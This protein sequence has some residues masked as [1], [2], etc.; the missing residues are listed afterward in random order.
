[1]SETK[2][3][4]NINWLWLRSLIRIVEDSDNLK[5]LI[6][7]VTGSLKN[8][9]GFEECE[10]FIV[11]NAESDKSSIDNLA[12]SPFFSRNVIQ[13]IFLYKRPSRSSP[14]EIVFPLESCE[15]ILGLFYI[16]SP[17]PLDDSDLELLWSFADHISSLIDDIQIPDKV[18]ANAKIKEISNSIFNNLKSFLE[19]SLER[20]KVLEEQNLQLVELNKTR[21]E[22][23]NNVSHE[24]RTP[25][26]SI[27]GFS[28]ILQR[29]E[30]K[31]ELIREASEQILSAGSR[32]S[33]MIDDLIQLNR[34]SN[35]GWDLHVERLDIGEIARYVVDSLA[36]LNKNHNFVFDFPDDYPLIDG[37]RRL[38]RQVIENLLINA[39]KYS[40]DG[41]EIKSLIDL[42]PD[43]NI[44]R[45]KIMDQGIGMTKEEHARAFDR[46]YR[47]KNSKTENIAGLGLGLSICKD[48]IE[49]MHGTISSY[50]EFGQGSTFMISFNY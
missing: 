50:S 47:A 20:L 35:K 6:E 49:A 29:H 41:G 1:M 26:V 39:I 21:T 14:Y 34:A 25:L 2:S 23:I 48:V 22:L 40:P 19:A 28:N 38:I 44:L 45:F 16:K 27:M 24:L 30:I 13:E 42:D 3:N 9:L 8:Y 7:K 46:F 31:P 18:N 36:P 43:K 17:N 12:S 15:R 11:D 37:D 4:T 5:T 33:R 10:I 32:L